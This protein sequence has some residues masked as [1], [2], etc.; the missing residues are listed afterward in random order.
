MAS[1]RAV[2]LL[3]ESVDQIIDRICAE[4]NQAQ[5]DASVRR[6]LASIDENTALQ[7]LRQ[8]SR[9]KI[10]NL[11]AYIIFM[12]S[13]PPFASSSSSTLPPRSP[14][15]SFSSPNWSP[16]SSSASPNYSIKRY[17]SAIPQSMKENRF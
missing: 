2:V 14:D 8:I 11:S 6:R 9:S 10:R 15:V 12:L 7:L 17:F 5:P 16:S 3:P 1:P 4:Q 13:R